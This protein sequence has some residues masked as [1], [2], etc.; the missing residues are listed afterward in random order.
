[1]SSLEVPSFA[2]S[3]PADARRSLFIYTLLVPFVFAA[4]L[5]GLL[6]RMIR[7]G[8]FRD[9]FGQRLGFYSATD[10]ARLEGGDW[11]WI[12]SISVGE[13]LVALKLAAELQ[14]LDTTIRIVLS[15]TTSTGF[16]LARNS[17]SERLQPIY[18]PI[19]LVRILRRLFA[20]IQPRQL[21]LIEGEAWPNLVAECRLRRIP[22]ALAEARLSPRSEA[23]FQRFRKWTGPIFR[24]VDVICVPEEADVIRWQRLGVNAAHIR[25]TGS[26]K[27][28]QPSG[29]PSRAKEFQLLLE[30]AGISP[31][32]PIVLGGSTHRGEERLLAEMLPHLRKAAPGVCL[33]LAPRHVERSAEILHVLQ[34][35]CPALRVA[36]RTAFPEHSQRVDILILDTTGELRDWYELATVVF[37][38]KSLTATGGQ[39]PAEPALLGKPV[40]FGPH[41]ENFAALVRLLLSRDGAR[42]IRDAAALESELVSLLTD[43][44][45]RELLGTNAMKALLAHRGAA[46]RTAELLHAL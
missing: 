15:A 17:A 35:C 28:D 1:M 25:F 6:L 24:L 12:H 7:R 27:F 42:Q 10:R 14:Q 11:V 41:M 39:N 22:I 45:Q 21:I 30:S 44:E 36:R 23:R 34:T 33:L 9:K 26:V 16:A 8:G 19:D 32:T 18:N 29:T 13:T 31:S 5:P 2:G 37:I 46:R 40:V 38:G 3:L 43:R 20:I 4:L